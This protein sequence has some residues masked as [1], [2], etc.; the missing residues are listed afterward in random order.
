MSP[1]PDYVISLPNTKSGFYKTMAGLLVVF[2]LTGFSTMAW[3][4]NGQDNQRWAFLALFITVINFGLEWFFRKKHQAATA[5]QQSLIWY[6]V[7]WL[8]FLRFYWIG[9]LSA[10]LTILYILSVRKLDV[11]FSRHAIRYPSFPART[12]RWYALNNVVLK[13]GLLTL[14]F[15][16]NKLIQQLIA[17]DCKVDETAF[18]AYC[19]HQL[20][21][22]PPTA[23]D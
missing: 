21:Q 13:D 17:E 18:T 8:F 7:I 20:Q 15:K 6:S 22:K 14:D 3:Y 5:I 2:Q 16:N 12:I 11:L 4:L 9:L 19:Q 23:A 10:V 1:T